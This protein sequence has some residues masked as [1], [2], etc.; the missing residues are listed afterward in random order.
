MARTVVVDR[1]AMSPE[2][3]KAITRGELAEIDR[4]L[5]EGAEVD[6]RDRYGQ[7]GLLIAA[8]L[9]YREVVER[10]IGHGA[11][12][13]RTAKFRL[14]PLMLAAMG[15]HGDIVHI[16]VGA[17]ADVSLQGSGAPGFAGRTAADLARHHGHEELA[18]WL[19]QSGTRSL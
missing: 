16:L 4:L 17:G 8:R 11:D 13:N 19:E 18:T 2:W 3:E 10:L 12:L 5:A 1:P 14:S 7:T 15:G 6:A 9:G